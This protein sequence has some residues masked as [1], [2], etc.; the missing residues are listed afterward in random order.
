M[1]ILI[2]EDTISYDETVVNAKEIDTIILRPDQQSVSIVLSGG[3]PMTH[4]AID[5]DQ[6][7]TIVDDVRD[8]AE[9]NGVDYREE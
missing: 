9:R 1:N 2:T 3:E 8:F 5:D 7:D 6:L 4:T